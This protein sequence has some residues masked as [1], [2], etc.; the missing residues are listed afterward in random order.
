MLAER[1]ILGS[2]A[3]DSFWVFTSN[4]NKNLKK[5]PTNKQQIYTSDYSS[6]AERKL[7]GSTP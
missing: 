6:N 5:K 2:W 4:K 1:A 3:V 7:L